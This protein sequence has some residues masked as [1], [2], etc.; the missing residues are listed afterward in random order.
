MGLRDRFKDMVKSSVSKRLAS[1]NIRT[2]SEPRPSRPTS[3]APAGD[4]APAGVDFEPPPTRRIVRAPAIAEVVESAEGPGVRIKAQPATDGQEC[5]FLVDRPVLAGR[6]WWFGSAESATGSPLPEALFNLGGVA[7]VLLDDTTVVV[8]PLTVMQSWR[9]LA[10]RIG[11]TLRAHVEDGGPAVADAV[12]EAIPDEETLRGHVQSVIDDV[13][14][15]G[16]AAH[17]GHISLTRLRGNSVYIEMGGGCQGCSAASVTLRQGIHGTLRE[18][19]P[20]VGAIYDD[21]DH[22]AGLNPYFR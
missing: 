7:S 3:V 2:S 16:V 13:I 5:R 4:V 9:P 11:A 12:L 14:N 18:R 1:F 17:S 6:S 8:T 19:V 15:P 21:T 22:A 10:E 20:E